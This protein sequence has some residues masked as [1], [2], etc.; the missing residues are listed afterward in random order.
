MRVFAEREIEPTRLVPD[1]IDA[2]GRESFLA[3]A[4]RAQAEAV[5]RY[6]VFVMGASMYR[7][8]RKLKTD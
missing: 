5:N 7:L 4:L 2:D 6:T 1:C 8:S 3:I